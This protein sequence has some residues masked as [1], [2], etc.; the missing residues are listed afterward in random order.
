VKEDERPDLTAASR[1][2]TREIVDT[3]TLNVLAHGRRFTTRAQALQSG[4]AA[5]ERRR[6]YSQKL[7]AR[8]Q[9]QE[10]PRLFCSIC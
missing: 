1:I 7:L 2:L 6:D 9:Q 5:W 4:R 3:E 8:G 10:S